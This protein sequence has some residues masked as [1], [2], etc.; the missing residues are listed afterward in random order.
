M[1]RKLY[2]YIK[3]KKEIING[4]KQNAK[5]MS[6]G[7]YVLDDS[8]KYITRNDDITKK[9]AYKILQTSYY[10]ALIRF[11]VYILRNTLFRKKF[12]IHEQDNQINDF[13]GTVYRPIRSSTGYSDSKIFDFAGNQVLSIFTEE[14]DHRS[15]IERYEY[16]NI[17]FPMP[18]VLWSN[19]EHLLIMEELIG[20]QPT[21]TWVK[22]DYLYVME[23][24]FSRYFAYFIVCKTKGIAAL[25]SPSDLLDTLS[26]HHKI[27]VIR[28]KISLELVDLIMPY[29]KLHGDLWTANILLEKTD[30]H[31]IKYIDWEYSNEF[32][33]FYDLFHLMWLE[34]YVNNN[35]IYI[36]KYANGEY[37]HY[38]KKMFTLFN[39]PYKEEL[40]LDYFSIYFLNFYQERLVQLH[41]VDKKNY[42]NQ[43]IRLLEKLKNKTR[44]LPFSQSI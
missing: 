43:F 27:N 14:K 28:S 40:R 25:Y 34:V 30:K 13:L 11:I 5:Y 23:E 39:I 12:T 18:A 29:V 2:R 41:E 6:S 3:R 19:K 1:I 36:E 38:F 7:Q 21:N 24:I 26:E 35:S 44:L 37:D 15:V 8:I 9:R 42:I 16:F 4:F 32:I 31:Q 10:P 20:F 22:E 33:F 17:Y